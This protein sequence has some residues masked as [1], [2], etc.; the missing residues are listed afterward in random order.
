MC[1]AVF[2]WSPHTA[3][4]LTLAAN[5]DEFFARPTRAMHWWRDA[6]LLAG[7]DL[8]SGG[9]WL[10]ITHAGRFALV[11][12]I[13]NPALR[14][15]SASS[16]GALVA[17]YL[18][19][20]ATAREFLT[21]LT[22]NL[23][24]FEGF[25]LLCGALRGNAKTRAPSLCFLNSAEGVVRE[26]D[27]GVY[28]VSNASLN[29]P[30]PKVQRVTSSF[31]DALQLSDPALQQ[32]QLQQLL[33][34]ATIAEDDD[35]PSTGV[36]REWERA[37]SPVFIRYAQSDSAALAYGTRSSTLVQVRD[38][39]VHVQEIEHDADRINARAAAFDFELADRR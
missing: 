1:I 30:W 25:N 19:G 4:P 38:H 29:T 7:R 10:G 36:S 14:K 33:L 3:Q 11:T 2:E 6:P 23:S 39:R 26:L 5:R 35:L 9:T 32:H 34:D 21:E 20:D 24:A 22:R 17:D 15:S 16:R 12:N 27:A 31:A 8:K 28:A 18:I 37:L 13:R